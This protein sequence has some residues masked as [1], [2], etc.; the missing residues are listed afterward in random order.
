[1]SKPNGPNFCEID[2]KLYVRV[3]YRAADGKWKSKTKRVS[4]QREGLKLIAK[5]K[6]ELNDAGSAAFD[7][8]KMLFDEL[9]AEYKR[10]H[11][12]KSPWYLDP[13]GEFF[14]GR[15]IRTITYADC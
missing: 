10:A 3:Y 9:L 4:S 6:A 7:G 14:K 2:G 11:P 8:D 5:L 12:D 1:M 15:R 13:I